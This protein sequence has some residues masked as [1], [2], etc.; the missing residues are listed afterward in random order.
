MSQASQFAP[1]KNPDEK[2]K[3]NKTTNK[4]NPHHISPGM[5]KQAINNRNIWGEEEKFPNKKFKNANSTII[6]KTMS[7][8][9]V[10]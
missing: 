10:K 2:T 7:N 4:K 1:S 3:Q 6:K 9:Y 5:D 8:G